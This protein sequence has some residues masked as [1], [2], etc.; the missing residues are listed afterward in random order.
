MD[1][2]VSELGGETGNKNE[3]RNGSTSRGGMRNFRGASS[4]EVDIVD[5]L[6]EVFGFSRLREGQKVAI[7]AALCGQD[8]LVVMATGAGKV[9]RPLKQVSPIVLP[10]IGV[11]FTACLFA[12]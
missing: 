2:Y 11:H 12:C 5:K 7:N 6:R 4:T 9:R 3:D 8:S 10:L 1:K